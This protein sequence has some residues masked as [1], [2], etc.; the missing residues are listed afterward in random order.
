MKTEGLL[1]DVTKDNLA[2]IGCDEE[3]TNSRT[4]KTD[5]SSSTNTM[6]LDGVANPIFRHSPTNQTIRLK[7]NCPSVEPT[8]YIWDFHEN[9]WR[10]TLGIAFF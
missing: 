8:N 1:Q 7:S 3:Q 4:S 6:E 10:L 9:E 2:G 5:L